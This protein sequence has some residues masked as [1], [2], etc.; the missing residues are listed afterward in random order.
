VS[1][2]PPYLWSK[3]VAFTTRARIADLAA[4]I[5]PSPIPLS[6]MLRIFGA[7]ASSCWSWHW[8]GSLFHRRAYDALL[9]TSSR[10][11]LQRSVQSCTL[12]N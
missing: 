3:V 5:T 6:G 8:A 10:S 4:E 2:R 1:R 7:L 9:C 12:A 11:S